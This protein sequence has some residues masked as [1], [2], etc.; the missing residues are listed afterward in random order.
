MP[1]GF[2][3]VTIDFHQNV[4]YDSFQRM[5]SGLLSST[6]PDPAEPSSWRIEEGQLIYGNGSDGVG[7]T[8]VGFFGDGLTLGADGLPTGFIEGMT[9]YDAFGNAVATC[10]PFENGDLSITDIL[11]DA[12]NSSSVDYGPRGHPA[13]FET[14]HGDVPWKTVGDG[15]RNVL[16][17][18]GR[19]DILLGRGGNDLFYFY[20][21]I[22]K[23]VGGGGRRD[24]LDLYEAPSGATILLDM[25]KAILDGRTTKLKGVEAVNGSDFDDTITGDGKKNILRGF[26]GKDT[27]TGQDNDK[28]FGGD[29]RD[30]LI[31]TGS[32]NK[33]FGGRHKDKL[34]AEAGG[35][36]LNGGPGHDR[37]VSKAGDNT[38][39]GQAGDDLLVSRTGN[40]ILTGGRGEDTFLFESVHASNFNT[41]RDYEAGEDIILDMSREEFQDV[42]VVKQ[43]NDTL[44]SYETSPGV[45]FE[46]L[47]LNTTPA[48]IDLSYD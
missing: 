8:L 13:F 26:D 15:E 21:D 23:I 22:K 44:I 1:A 31:V 39:N 28:L 34:I 2:S 20:T 12:A 37:L 18:Y 42:T 48:D 7:D 6:S 24:L 27:L 9:V 25:G 5:L 36:I 35:N 3:G 11:K 47:V 43:G 41:I 45:Q 40:D 16:E 32:G 4:G 14:L 19:Q 10:G 17:G 29:G 33:L 30:T 46:V 38:L